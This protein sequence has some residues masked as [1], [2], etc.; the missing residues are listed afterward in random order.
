MDNHTH[1]RPDSQGYAIDRAMG[2]MKVFDLERADDRRLSRG[3]FVEFCRIQQP[4]FLK[5]F[6]DERQRELGSIYRNV[7]VAKDVGNT[8][9]VIFMRVRE[10]DRAYHTFVLLQ[11][12]DVRDNDVYAEQFLL[13]EH[14][15]GINDDNVVTEAQ[16]KHVHSE[17]AQSAQRN[18]P[19][20]SCTQVFISAFQPSPSTS[21]RSEVAKL[22]S[23]LSGPEASR[24]HRITPVISSQFSGGFAYRKHLKALT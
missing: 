18:G 9:D 22:A 5:L 17:F 2:D 23:S 6:A 7:Q 15:P 8:T 10:D 14:E 3:Y 13:G 11:V 24:R 4:V 20:R 16:C 1:G 12:C 19:Q 21:V